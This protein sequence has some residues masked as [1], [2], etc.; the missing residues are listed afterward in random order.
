MPRV[1]PDQVRPGIGIVLGDFG[2]EVQGIEHLEIARKSGQ[3]FLVP[4][5]RK[6]VNRVVVGPV[7]LSNAPIPLPTSYGMSPALRLRNSPPFK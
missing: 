2:Q 3:E 7:G 6:A 5:L 4:R 1:V